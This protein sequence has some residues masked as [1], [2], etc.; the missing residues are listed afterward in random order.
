MVNTQTSS[1]P[2]GYR[3]YEQRGLPIANSTYN[4]EK[5][6]ILI[7]LHFSYDFVSFV[8]PRS[9][10]NEGMTEGRETPHTTALIRISQKRKIASIEDDDASCSKQ[11]QQSSEVNSAPITQSYSANKKICNSFLNPQDSESETVNSC[12]IVNEVVSE[13]RASTSMSIVDDGQNSHENDIGRWVG[14]SFVLTTEKRMEML[15]R[16]WVPPET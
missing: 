16:C 4:T 13:S 10:E 11:L 6:I 2:I 7:S 3:F 5:G 14:R 15:K 9:R 12:N 1:I 8:P